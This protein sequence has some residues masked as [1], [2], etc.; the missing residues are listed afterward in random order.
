[1]NGQKSITLNPSDY[2][3]TKSQIFNR[4]TPSRPDV[5]L[6]L[7]CDTNLF[8]AVKSRSE[9]SKVVWPIFRH[10]IACAKSKIVATILILQ[11][12]RAIAIISLFL[13]C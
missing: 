2:R 3:L 11:P 8:I 5:S 10:A 1:M 7:R 6:H 13:L 12:A 4:V 9:Q